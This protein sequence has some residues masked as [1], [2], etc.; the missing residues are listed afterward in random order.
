MNSILTGGDAVGGRLLISYVAGDIFVFS[1][2]KQTLKAWKPWWDCVSILFEFQN[3]E[4][5]EERSEWMLYWVAGVAPL[6]TVGHVL[7]KSDALASVI[8]KIELDKFWTEMK[9]AR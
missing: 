4:I 9:S 6:R 5:D 7:A 3:S 8:H 2:P 1:P